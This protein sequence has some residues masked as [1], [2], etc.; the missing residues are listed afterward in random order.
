MLQHLA[1]EFS[2]DS[3]RRQQRQ[4]QN[5]VHNHVKE[6]AA[7]GRF[8]GSATQMLHSSLAFQQLRGS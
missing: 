2:G 8:R 4:S 5:R 3:G 1:A 6:V 7:D